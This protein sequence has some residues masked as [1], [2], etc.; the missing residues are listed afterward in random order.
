MK[1]Q[2][3]H[4]LCFVIISLL[5]STTFAFGQT[6]VDQN[7]RWAY[8]TSTG[9]IGKGPDSHPTGYTTVYSFGEPEEVDTFIYHRL[10]TAEEFQETAF[11]AD[12]DILMREDSLSRVY[13]KNGEEPEILIYD[14]SLEINDVFQ[15][16]IDGCS[17]TLSATDVITT[18]SGE[19]R[20]LFIFDNGTMW[21]K[22]IG[23][24]TS[25]IPDCTP[26]EGGLVCFQAGVDLEYTGPLYFDT[27]NCLFVPVSTE[28]IGLSTIQLFPNPVQHFLSIEAEG[29]S[30]AGGLIIYNATGQRIHQET[31]P[32][33]QHYEVDLSRYPA[34]IYYLELGELKRTFTKMD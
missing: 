1:N 16:P 2:L 9:Q 14:F 29:K 31:V 27:D 19:L 33:V 6:F 22:G 30:L 18:N 8:Y 34:G 24:L 21:V 11:W 12:T 23:S 10:Q 15:E 20:E 28:E 4:L 17:L 3:L 32:Q 25:M 5:L 7:N 13:M 26:G